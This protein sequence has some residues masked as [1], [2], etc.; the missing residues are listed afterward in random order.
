MT[1]GL[2]GIFRGGCSMLLPQLLGIS[3]VTFLLIRLL[4]GNPAYHLLGPLA[5]DSAVAELSHKMGLGPVATR[6]IPPV[7]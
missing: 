6:S 2:V 5:T 7:S 1:C 3:F 4:P